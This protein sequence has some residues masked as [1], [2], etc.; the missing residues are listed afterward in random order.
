MYNRMEPLPPAPWPISREDYIRLARYQVPLS[1][2]MPPGCLPEVHVQEGEPYTLTLEDCLE[3]LKRHLDSGE[4][5]EVFLR[6]WYA[7]FGPV[8]EDICDTLPPSFDIYPE[9]DM[10]RA[11]RWL[12]PFSCPPLAALCRQLEEYLADRDLPVLRRRYP[13]S[14]R[15]ILIAR[16]SNPW[17]M[18]LATGEELELYRRF[19]AEGAA[20][21]K[22]GAL[23]ALALGSFGGNRAFACDWALA[24]SCLLKLFHSAAPAKT[25]GEYAV[26]LGDLAMGRFGCG[27]TP[28][29]SEA[30]QYYSYAHAQNLVDGGMRLADLYL[31]GKGTFP[32]R[33]TASQ[34]LHELYYHQREAFL[35]GEA[36]CFPELALRLARFYRKDY[37]EAFLFYAHQAVFGFR[38]RA[39]EAPAFDDRLN[40]KAACA[41]LKEA[42]A[43]QKSR[44][45]RRARLDLF[46]VLKSISAPE[47]CTLVLRALPASLPGQQG[48]F[49]R[50]VIQP[51][52]KE[53][54]LFLTLP[55]LGVCGFFKS[56]S[57]VG[58]LCG[59]LTFQERTL[60]FDSFRGSE[61]LLGGKSVFYFPH[62]ILPEVLCFRHGSHLLSLADVQPHFGGWPRQWICRRSLAP[63]QDAWYPAPGG[64]VAC[65]VLKTYRRPA[66][67]FPLYVPSLASSCSPFPEPPGPPAPL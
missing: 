41:L 57:F 25:R 37:P 34:L 16:L 12:T 55:A 5:D 20:Q 31:E 52:C 66:S 33:E 48:C 10:W 26:L 23:R 30:F 67:H 64:P 18:E 44:P 61:L 59:S 3:A 53:D 50:F 62:Y 15:S 28:N 56:L 1:R 17:A 32:C 54:R 29:Y 35:Q 60:L 27:L 47:D 9:E 36:A 51:L 19:V 38:T 24:R 46:S 4:E 6:E 63:G 43:A 40:I 45:A 7:F 49:V 2:L 22:P 14:A 65:R 13:A 11:L 58:S 39:D 42:R 8:I 21:N